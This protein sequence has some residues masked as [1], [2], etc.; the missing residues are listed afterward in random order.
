M[1]YIDKRPLSISSDLLVETIGS[2]YWLV[3]RTKL[4][5]FLGSSSASSR[6]I[7]KR[8]WTCFKIDQVNILLNEKERVTYGCVNP[9]NGPL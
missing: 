3:G 7:T 4:I 8:D 5:K 1:G 6:V 9:K 2:D